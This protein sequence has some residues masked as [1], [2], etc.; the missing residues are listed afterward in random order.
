MVFMNDYLALVQRDKWRLRTG[1]RTSDQSTGEAGPWF[2]QKWPD[3][4]LGSI[5]PQREQG[6]VGLVSAFYRGE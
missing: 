5:H 3:G 1:R 2:F 4:R 6:S